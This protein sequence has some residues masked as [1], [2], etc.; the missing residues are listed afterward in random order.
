MPLSHNAGIFL[1]YNCIQYC[2]NIVYNILRHT[3]TAFVYSEGN[4]FRGTRH[5]LEQNNKSPRVVVKVPLQPV[6]AGGIIIDV[7]NVVTNHSNMM[8]R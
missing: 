6:S 2:I 1:Y 7:E 3:R 5:V 4:D 8:A